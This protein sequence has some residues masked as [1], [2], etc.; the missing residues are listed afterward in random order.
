MTKKIFSSTK[1]QQEFSTSSLTPELSQ[2]QLWLNQV[3]PKEQRSQIRHLEM[4][5][6]RLQGSLDL[7]D[8]VSLEELYCYNNQL[9]EIK[10]ADS[11]LNKLR[12]LHVGDNNFPEQNLSLFS[13][14]VLV[15]L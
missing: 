11:S 3:Y 8:F 6:E 9:T 5:G 12:V 7:T 4:S 10:F 15:A 13:C 14:F 1:E 2:V